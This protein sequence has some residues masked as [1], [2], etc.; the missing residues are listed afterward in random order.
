[1][2]AGPRRPLGLQTSIALQVRGER[3]GVVGGGKSGLAAAKLLGQLGAKVLLSDKTKIS[4]RGLSNVESEVGHSARLLESRLLV[5]SPGVPNHLPVLKHAAD[6]H[7]P[8][9]SELELGARMATPRYLIAITGTN[10]KTTTTTLV[11]QLFKAA[12]RR[13]WVGGNIGTPFSAFAPRVRASDSVVLEVSSYQL[14]DIHQFHPTV[15]AILNVTPDHLEHHGSMA[16]YAAA[17][18]R[19]FENQRRHDVCVL[20]ADDAWCRRLAK[21]CRGRVLFFSSQRSL[22]SGVFFSE[23]QIHCRWEKINEQWPLD[24]RLPGAHN[25]QNALAAVGIS[26]ASG[27]ASRTTRSVLREFKGVEHRLEWV[28][29][30]AG[31]RYFN[32]SK[33][34]NVDSTRVALQSFSDPLIVIMGGRG[35]G[36][37]YTPLASVIRRHVKRILLIGEDGRRIRTELQGTVPM[38]QVGTMDAAVRRARDVAVAGDVVLLSPACASFDQYQNFEHRGTHF[39]SLV[40]HL[41]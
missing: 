40:R 12:G 39:K 23:G 3:V 18:A 1:V 37:P 31:V 24:W 11:A 20:N 32:D 22:R 41:R 26:L 38:D 2:T 13:T 4:T 34:T 36:N 27:I 19:I 25:V 6:R 9:W 28:R 17:K 7:I 16:S 8:I 29:S 14:E 30:V 33:A 35:K 5:R 15:S 10:G 21:R